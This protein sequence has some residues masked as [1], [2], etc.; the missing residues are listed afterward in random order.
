LKTNGRTADCKI[1]RGVLGLRKIIFV[2][3]GIFIIASI[4]CAVFAAINWFS[5]GERKVTGDKTANINVMLSRT[6]NWERIAD[7]AIIPEKEMQMIDG[8]TAT[9]PITAEIL[10]QFY[11]YTDEEINESD[12]VW[13]STTHSAYENLIEKSIETSLVFVTSPSAEEKELAKTENVELDMEQI[14]R[15]AFVFITH[16]SN[17]VESLTIEQ[18]QKIYT[19]E[20]T[21]WNELGGNNSS[22]KAYQREENSGSQTAMEQIVMKGRK[23]INPI[24]EDYHLV[25]HGM[26]DLVRAVAEYDNEKASIGYTYN[27]YINNLYKNDNI[28]VL[29]ING[30]APDNTNI[31]NEVYPFTTSYYGIIRKD[32]PENSYARTLRNF[33]LTDKG[34]DLIEMA[35]YC[36]RK[37]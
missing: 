15:D 20:I 35:G 19:G 2:F 23:M 30:V 10:R 21:N 9:I 32:E 36:R 27:Y 11:E 5:P 16:K 17:P 28:K 33:L 31:I 7:E 1:W 37:E 14:A 4:A 25:V 13:H 3:S 8:S 34:Q 26:P 22:I 18:I 29:K 12:Y 6:D 24:E